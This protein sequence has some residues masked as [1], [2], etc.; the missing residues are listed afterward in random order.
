[1]DTNREN[2]QQ[3]FTSL[4]TRFKAGLEAVRSPREG[5]LSLDD[6]A[7]SAP[8][9]GSAVVHG[10]LTQLPGMKKW[11][12][13][14]QIENLL[15]GKLTVANDDFEGTIGV[16][17]NDIE[18]DNYGLYGNLAQAMGTSA[19][20]LWMDLAI[21]ALVANGNWADGAAFFGTTRK[22]GARTIANKTTS[23]LD[24][25][26][27]AAAVTAMMSWKGHKDVPLKVMPTKLVVGPKL[28][29][30][31]FQICKA[32][33]F[34][35]IVTNKAGSE[36]VGAASVDNP[37]RG[38]VE[39]K[40]SPSLVGDYDDHW[41]LVGEVNGVKPVMVQKRKEP[42]FVSMDKD[43]DEN[44]FMRKTFLYGTDAR[45]AA[46]LTLPHLCYAGIL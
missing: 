13:D 9:S 35:Q 4:E 5:F 24:A 32:A 46:F 31:A 12:G 38:V 26:T 6:I 29:T 3:F 21:A 44:V 16:P 30:A 1:M 17:R 11:L 15:T 10:W 40:I 28:R 45:G 39:P 18:D 34:V 22:Y 20:M 33:N 41:Y 37:N 42:K 7:L 2:M 14:R 36:N 43:T 19:E 25:D 23:A 8:V 27:F